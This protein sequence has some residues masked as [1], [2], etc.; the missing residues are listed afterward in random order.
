MAPLV[1]TLKRWRVAAEVRG[2]GLH[3]AAVLARVVR[4]TSLPCHHA[5]Q[6]ASSG[7]PPAL[8]VRT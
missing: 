6:D 5:R 2:V 1:G 4:P 8:C 3:A 7:V